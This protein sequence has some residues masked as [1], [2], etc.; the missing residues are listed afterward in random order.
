MI[1]FNVRTL[2]GA[3]AAPFPTFIEPCKPTLKP[4]LPVGDKWQYEIKFDA[5]GRNCICAAARQ[6][7]H[8]QRA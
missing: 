3:K 5:T 1:H 8:Q 7:C 6:P 4:K 2:K